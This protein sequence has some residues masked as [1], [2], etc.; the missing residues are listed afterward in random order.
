MR[1]G[2]DTTELAIGIMSGTSGDGIDAALIEATW[3]DP[4]LASALAPFVAPP[5]Q[6]GAPPQPAPPVRAS[7]PAPPRIRVLEHRAVR[8]PDRIR[9]AILAAGADRSVASDLARLHAQLGDAYTDVALQLIE[10]APEIDGEPGPVVVIGMHG[11][12]VA[13]LPRDGV[14]FQLGDAARVA[15]RTRLVTIADFRSADVAAG[16]EGAPLTPFADHVLFAAGAPR[17]VINLGGIANVTLLPDDDPDHVVGWDTGPANMVVDRI[18]RMTGRRYDEGGEGAR[19]GRVIR[20]ALDRALAHPF[21]ARPA[22]KS[23][24]REEF[25]DAFTRRL[26]DDVRAAGGDLYDALATAAALT[27][28]T[29]ADAIRGAS[30]PRGGWRDALCAG[31]GSAN[32]AL[33]RSVATALAPIPVRRTDDAGV[34]AEA[35]EAVAF[36][37]LGL[38]RIRGL[39]NT[40]PRCTGAAHAVSAGAIHVPVGRWMGFLVGVA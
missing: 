32:A 23:T 9:D 28:T 33:V 6:L 36:A 19:R 38:Y 27:G 8:F 21:F 39:P 15:L 5:S 20:E 34:P 29:I 14:T 2:A 24:G 3:S 37:I 35:R 10:A 25:G 1:R 30:V 13:H 12:T 16:G 4:A 31:G 40:L 18:A 22:P 11:Q 26:V 17:I 7:L